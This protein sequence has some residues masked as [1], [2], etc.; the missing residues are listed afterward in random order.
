MSLTR[1][2]RVA[3]FGV[4]LIGG[5]FALALRAAGFQGEIVGVSSPKTIADAIAGGVIDRGESAQ[6]AA[7]SSD[8]IYLSQPVLI[9]ASTLRTIAPWVREGTL[10]T[11][12]G[13][14]K[15]VIV[16][17]SSCL[18]NGMFIGGHPMAGKERSGVREADAGLFRG[19]PYVLCPATEEDRKSGLFEWLFEWIERIGAR[20]IVMTAPR[21][22]R[23]VAFVSH[24]PQLLSTALASVLSEIEGAQ[25]VAGPG[26]LELTRLAAS[27]FDMWRDILRTNHAHIEDA[28]TKVIVKLQNIQRDLQSDALAEEFSRAAKA[29]GVLRRNPSN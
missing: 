2:D 27:P 16:D 7:E 12:A 4:G 15:E 1:M 19:R 17:A 21:H 22:D 28:L 24:T 20:P 18:C 6:T 25:E 13:S 14:T 11:D 10:I 9:I 23:L 26:V 3:I 29:A 5:S 8:F